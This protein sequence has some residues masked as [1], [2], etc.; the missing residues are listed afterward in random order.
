[1]TVMTGGVGL[2]VRERERCGA[3]LARGKLGRLA[4]G[5]GPVG[6]WV[7]SFLFIFFLLPFSFI[8]EFL[9]WVFER[10]LLFK[11]E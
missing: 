5:V 6:C 1:M 7:S 3:G 4:P 11:F 8:S 10:V 2:S 9:F